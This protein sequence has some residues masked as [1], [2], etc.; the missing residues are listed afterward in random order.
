MLKTLLL[1]IPLSFLSL[2]EEELFEGRKLSWKEKD[3]LEITIIK[4]IEKKDCKQKSREGDII[5][6]FYKLEDKDGNEIG[7]N[8][9]Q[10]S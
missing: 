3:G 4:P 7:S 8:F 9:G 2:A 1:I 5:G 6:Q 10:T